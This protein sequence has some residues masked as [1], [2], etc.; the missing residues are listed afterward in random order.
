MTRIR[1]YGPSFVLA[2]MIAAVL[3]GGPH[4]VRQ[5]AHAQQVVEVQ[6]VRANLQ[7]SP[8]G[9]LS[10]AFR[11]VA[12]VVEPSVVHISVSR[13]TPNQPQGGQRPEGFE[14][15]P[16]TPEDLR[17]WFFE[18]RPDR[19]QPRQEE[20]QQQPPAPDYYRAPIPFG[21]GSGW[22]HPDGQHIITNNHV[23][24]EADQ[25]EV[26]FH[27]R[28]TAR[29]EV[30]G[31]DEQTDIAVLK[32]VQEKDLHPSEIA[33]EPVDRGDIVFAFG[34]PFG[35]EFSMSQGIVSGKGRQ[36][37]ILGSMGYENFIQ[38]DAAIN[39]GNSGGPL[40]NYHGQVVGMN[41]AIATET[42]GN[43]GIGFAIPADMI[44]GIVDQIIGSG[45]VTR[46]YLGV[47]IRD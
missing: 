11:D 40:T 30:V 9:D 46:G 38:T 34:S 32:L 37:G 36:I 2:L 8:L 41:T 26:K 31:R 29:A 5:L 21:N 39:Q 15:L 6:Q 33:E 23:I 12:R 44:V 10:R 14:G 43:M 28:T 25:I 17:R 45:S 27:D 13:Q 47:W 7:N 19:P 4:V 42:G 16:E 20:Q 3:L 22:I 18:R 35:F 1:S 24:R